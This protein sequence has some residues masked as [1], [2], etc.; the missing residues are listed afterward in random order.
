[1]CSRCYLQVMA[2][3]S[4]SM[5]VP[6]CPIGWKGLWIGYS[7]AM[8][9]ILSLLT[10]RCICCC[11]SVTELGC[12]AVC[13]QTMCVFKPLKFSVIFFTATPVLVNPWPKWVYYFV[14][15]FV[16]IYFAYQFLAWVVRCATA[17]F[18]SVRLSVHY[19][20]YPCPSGFLNWSVFTARP[21][22]I[23]VWE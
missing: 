2:V 19:T 1:M 7:F 16:R 18:L 11:T 5:M 12:L 15:V 10:T 14:T 20:T 8:A 9:S 17:N 3:H 22:V 23:G 13:S 21:V 6:E 4:Q